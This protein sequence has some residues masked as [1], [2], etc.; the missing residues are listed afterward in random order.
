M[1]ILEGLRAWARP[2]SR[3]KE[4]GWMVTALSA[5]ALDYVHCMRSAK[6]KATVT[7]SGRVRLDGGASGAERAVRELH[8]ERYQCATLLAAGDYQLVLVD[9]PNVQP[10]ELK[11]AIRWH[12]KNMLDYHV[13]DATLDVLDIPPDPSGGSRAHSMYAVAARNEVIKATIDRFEAA[14]IPLSVI[15]IAETAQRNLAALYEVEDSGVA[16]LYLGARDA[17]LT[18][19]KGGELYLAR[20]IDAGVEQLQGTGEAQREELMNRV[21]LELQRTLDHFDRQFRYVRVARMVLGPEPQD[22]GLAAFLAAN[23]DLPVVQARLADAIEFAGGAA[24]AG[25][26]EWRLFHLV[27]AALRHEAK[28][29]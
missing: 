13:D 10:A 16:M 17:L 27:G 26:G 4:P 6:G 19:S 2:G 18:I 1:G 11:T 20:R 3:G 5:D 12:I 15:D 8:L 23:L 14:R 24:P 22:S 25:E 21:V 9:A 29:L 28:A 7:R